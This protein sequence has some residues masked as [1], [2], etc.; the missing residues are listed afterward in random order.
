MPTAPQPETNQPPVTM[1]PASRWRT[2]LKNL[3]IVAFF[4]MQL[5]AALP[6]LLY[7]SYELYG[8]F[9]WN[10]YSILYRCDV[11]YNLIKTDGTRLPFDHRKLLNNP[12]RSYLFLNRSDLPAFNRFVCNTMSRRQD[13]KAVR[14]SAICQLNDYPPVQFIQQDVDIC[15]AANYGVLPP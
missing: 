13:M 8:H 15:S 2:R 3:S 6:G 9:S 5:S 11:H 10:M 7:N 14:A 1:F 4:G 12:T